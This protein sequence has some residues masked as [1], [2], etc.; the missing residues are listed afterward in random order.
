MALAGD[1]LDP[2]DLKVRLGCRDWGVILMASAFTWPT[3]ASP[4]LTI[5]RLL[6]ISS[7]GLTDSESGLRT[8]PLVWSSI[9]LFFLRLNL[10][11]LM[12]SRDLER[13]L[14]SGW[15]RVGESTISLIL[16]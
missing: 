7:L 12:D 3:A 8:L 4:G 1:L 16:S 13:G 11:S 2:G 9:E 14:S 6:P 15:G 10:L 5:W